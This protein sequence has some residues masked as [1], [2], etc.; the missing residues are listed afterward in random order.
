MNAVFAD[1]SFYIAFLSPRDSLHVAAKE[2][3]DS[4]NDRVVTTEY[5]LLEVA[6]YLADTKVRED[7][8]RLIA[9]LRADGQTEIVASTAHLWQRGFELYVQRSDKNW[10]LTDCISFV[11]ME[12][13]EIRDAL[14]ADHHFEQAGFTVLLR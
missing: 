7:V 8:G 12:E 5:V 2:F 14:T 13:R 3:G 1:A 6:N 4:Y 9:V 11:V 10:S